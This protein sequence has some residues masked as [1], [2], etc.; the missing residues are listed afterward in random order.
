MN[1]IIASLSLLL[2]SVSTAHSALVIEVSGGQLFAG[3]TGSVD[4]FISSDGIGGSDIVDFAS[5]HFQITGGG[6]SSSLGFVLSPD[7]TEESI[8]GMGVTNPYLFFGNSA[9]LEY[10]DLN[11]DAGNYVGVDSTDDGLGETLLTTDPKRL[12]VRLDLAAGGLGAFADETYAIS[13]VND[14]D[15]FFFGLDGNDPTVAFDNS[16]AGTITVSNSVSG[17]PEPSSFA[18]LAAMGTTWCWRRRVSQGKKRRV[19]MH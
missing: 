7:L 1:R 4:V 2:C 11:S 19:I 16:I 12:L 17:V 13:I 15:T 18:L 6:G 5:Y 9:G 14:V 3:T 8:G 10:N